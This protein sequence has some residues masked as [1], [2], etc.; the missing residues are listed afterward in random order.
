MLFTRNPLERATAKDCLKS[1]WIKRFT[2]E[3][4]A[5]DVE[6]EMRVLRREQ[7][8]LEDKVKIHEGQF[9]KQKQ[10]VQSN[11][12]QRQIAGDTSA[13]GLL[14]QLSEQRKN[15]QRDVDDFRTQLIGKEGA[16]RRG[17]LIR[18]PTEVQT[19]RHY[20]TTFNINGRTFD[21]QQ[22]RQ[23]IGSGIGRLEQTANTMETKR[24][25][26]R[27]MTRTSQNTMDSLN[28]S[29]NTSLT[30]FS[31]LGSEVRSRFGS[32]LSATAYSSLYSGRKKF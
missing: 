5:I 1:S 6:A 13:A 18:E 9:E 23:T 17:S 11:E 12:R 10:A 29:L 30:R 19:Q 20:D 26:I 21:V 2:P 3:G 22:T 25:E 28:R 27:R 8:E 15:L 32:D 14:R 7:K 4:K 31:S 24:T 16:K